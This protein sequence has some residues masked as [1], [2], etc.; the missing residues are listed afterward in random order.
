MKLFGGR[1]KDVGRYGRLLS[2]YDELS[3][4]FRYKI[5]AVLVVSCLGCEYLFPAMKRYGTL[6]PPGP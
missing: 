3:P 6:D 1:E 4:T 5:N 2:A